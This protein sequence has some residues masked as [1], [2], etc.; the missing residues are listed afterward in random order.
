MLI[1]IAL[2]SLAA[3]L[4]VARGLTR[5]ALEAS[6]LEPHAFPGLQTQL[7][8]AVTAETG[9]PTLDE[10]PPSAQPLAQ[11]SAPA[12]ASATTASA[13]TVA[14]H[15]P[16]PTALG[17]PAPSVVSEAPAQAAPAATIETRPPI[18]PS[19]PEP[20]APAPI[21]TTAPQD[22]ARKRE[23]A[24]IDPPAVAK[25][26]PPQPATAP[27]LTSGPTPQ[28]ELGIVAYTRCDGVPQLDKRF[29]CPRDL[30]LEARVRRAINALDHCALKA[31]QRGQGNVRLEF[32]RDLPVK[33]SIESP[34]R[35]G[36]DRA[37][38]SR[39]TGHALADVRTSFKPDLM[40]VL[41]YFGLR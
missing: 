5:D 29:P 19:T 28:V 20:T 39:C 8:P 1:A 13:P 17:S 3:G 2:A 36:F 14:E 32:E 35:G 22:V 16:E 27:A 33:A 18:P 9:E 12:P 10:T 6:S 34:R 37:A 41:F 38:V 23:R 40:V 24:A 21:A 4:S 30:R 26:A 11:P 15:S 31:E 7:T 25:S